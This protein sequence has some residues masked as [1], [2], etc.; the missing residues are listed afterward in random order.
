LFTGTFLIDVLAT[1]SRLTGGTV[2]DKDKPK[3]PGA[4]DLNLGHYC[5]RLFLI[6]Y[7]F[8]PKNAF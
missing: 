6:I 5:F 2:E 8:Y 4:L 1:S 3:P 7:N